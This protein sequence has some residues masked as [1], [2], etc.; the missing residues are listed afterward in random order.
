MHGRSAPEPITGRSA[1]RRYLAVCHCSSSPTLP[2]QKFHQSVVSS[3]SRQCWAASPSSHPSSNPRDNRPRETAARNDSCFAS[4]ST[5]R[6]TPLCLH[7]VPTLL[8]SGT[9]TRRHPTIPDLFLATYAMAPSP[10]RGT[11]AACVSKDATRGGGTRARPRNRQPSPAPI[12]ASKS[13]RRGR[14][15][16]SITFPTLRRRGRGRVAILRRSHQLR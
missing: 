6:G 3:A 7:A 4:D 13:S 12:K 5:K 2:R 8:L 1:T 9:V 10:C 15:Q 14:S 16:G 11:T